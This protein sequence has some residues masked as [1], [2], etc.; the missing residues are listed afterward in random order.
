MSYRVLTFDLATAR[1]REAIIPQ[2]R[3]VVSVTVL[4]VPAGGDVSLSWGSSGDAV[5]LLIAGQLVEFC[6]AEAGGFY[7]T[8]P[9]GIAG[10]LVLYVDYGGARMGVS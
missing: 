3:G 6:P 8:V 10:A 1:E 4:D 9:A 5:P 2:G 7:L